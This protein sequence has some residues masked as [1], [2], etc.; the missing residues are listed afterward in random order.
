[1]IA[2]TYKYH[3]AKIYLLEALEVCDSMNI[4]ESTPTV[5]LLRQDTHQMLAQLESMRPAEELRMKRE[6]TLALAS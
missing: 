1:M 3:V 2:A 5:K 6:Y 4:I